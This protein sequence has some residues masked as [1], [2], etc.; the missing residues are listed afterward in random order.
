MK[1]PNFKLNIP[2]KVANKASRVAFKVKKASPE[3]LVGVGIVGIGAS[4]VSACLATRKIDDILDAAKK[5]VETIHAVS[6]DESKKDIYSEKDHNRDLAITYIQMGFKIVKL[7]LPAALI[8]GASIYCIVKSH[9]VMKKR[10]FALTTAYAALKNDFGGY[11]SRVVE[12]FGENVDKELKYNIKA[13]EFEETVIDE[14]TGK[15]KTIKKKVNVIDPTLPS[16]YARYFDDSCYGW[17][18]NSDYSLMFLR[19]LQKMMNDRLRARGHLFLNEVYDEL[20]IPRTE[21]GQLAGWVY[22]P[23]NP[24]GD[25]YVDFGIF[26]GYREANRDFV[27]GYK[28]VILLD[29]NCDG[30]IMSQMQKRPH[31]FKHHDKGWK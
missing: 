31:C 30:D 22:D 28:N 3:I 25:N 9:D 6:K 1:K 11:R 24:L 15:E 14:K 18:E 12:R 16:E 7:Y 19:G 10:N 13:K 29:F 21:L 5:D 8:T 27:N 26:D 2:E 23:E 20:N 17:E 4:I